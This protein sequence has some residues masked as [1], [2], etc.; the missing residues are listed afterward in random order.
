MKRNPQKYNKFKES[1]CVAC[2]HNGSFYPLDVDHVITFKS[3]PELAY[4]K[5]NLMTLCRKCHT[6]KGQKGTDYMAN[7]FPSVKEWL[8][9]NNWYKCEL[10][11]K[12]R[13]DLTKSL[14]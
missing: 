2:G 13:L 12:W 9:K 4:T 11:N 8:I 3:H 5:G 10:T 1:F 6:L 14:N 7:K